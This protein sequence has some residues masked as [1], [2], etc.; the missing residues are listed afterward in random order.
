MKFKI[1]IT[2]NNAAFK[3]DPA[4][5]VRI[6][7]QSLCNDLA[8]NTLEEVAESSLYDLNGNKV[9]RVEVSK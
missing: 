5:Q 4:A 1:T 8:S 2:C 3:E 9:G 7:L 6:I